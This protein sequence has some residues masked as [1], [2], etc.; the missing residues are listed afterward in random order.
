[1]SLIILITRNW[2][3]YH[4]EAVGICS[5]P[6]SGQ[7]RAPT[8]CPRHSSLCLTAVPFSNYLPPNRSHLASVR[9]SGLTTKNERSK[10]FHDNNASSA[11]LHWFSYKCTMDCFRTEHVCDEAIALMANDMC[12]TMM[13]VPLFS[14]TPDIGVIQK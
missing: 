1:M 4:M 6:H 8:C 5:V 14:V 11:L 9:L 2:I 12:E 3:G 10:L 13:T 7:S